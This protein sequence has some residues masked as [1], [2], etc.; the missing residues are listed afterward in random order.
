MKKLILLSAALI[1]SGM[2][3]AQLIPGF[4][5]GPKIGASFSKF[6]TDVDQIKTEAKSTF[7]FGAFARFGQK[8]YFQPELLINSRKGI[9]KDEESTGGNTSLKVGTVEV[10]L[11]LGV[12]I[13]NLK[14]INVRAMAGPAASIVVNKSITTEN[15]NDAIGKDDIRNAIWGLQFGAGVDVL[16]FTVDLRYELG[17]NDISK[18]STFD[19]KNNMFTV[20]IG[21]KIL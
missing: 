15:W 11:L 18:I 2:A 14:V 3:S 4:S 1:I 21:W 19:L 8:V 20:G 13:L 10:P 6:T 5:V 9:L 7:H 17:L 12:R 16:M